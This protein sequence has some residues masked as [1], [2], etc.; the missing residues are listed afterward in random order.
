MDIY[1]ILDKIKEYCNT[2]TLET[3]E[4]IM[5]NI[6]SMLN[7]IPENSY[8]KI[9]DKVKEY[10]KILNELYIERMREQGKI[11]PIYIENFINPSNN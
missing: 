8:I 4:T 2:A 11:Y 10:M 9:A 6:D 1:E 5:K 3:I 7:S